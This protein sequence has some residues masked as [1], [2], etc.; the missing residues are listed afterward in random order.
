MK[1]LGFHTHFHTPPHPEV[2]IG[3][4][5]GCLFLNKFHQ[6]FHTPYPSSLCNPGAAFARSWSLP[7]CLPSIWMIV[8][9][10]FSYPFSYPGHGQRFHYTSGG[11]FHTPSRRGVGGTGGVGLTILHVFWHPFMWFSY[12]FSYPPFSYPLFSDIQISSGIKIHRHIYI[13]RDHHINYI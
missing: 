10:Q 11:C 8:F 3:V 4:F 13:C 1:T 7:K 5:I 2:F 9:I 12:P 6:Y